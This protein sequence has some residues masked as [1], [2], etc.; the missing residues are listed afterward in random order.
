MK[1]NKVIAPH[2]IPMAKG[3]IIVPRRSHPR[4]VRPRQWHV[5]K[6]CHTVEKE[7]RRRG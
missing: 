5:T 6:G 1:L 4:T 3:T 2:V 7:L